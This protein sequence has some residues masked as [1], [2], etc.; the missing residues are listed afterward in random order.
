METCGC[1]KKEM[2]R[3]TNGQPVRVE[4]RNGVTT[5]Y[6][7]GVYGEFA[8]VLAREPDGPVKWNRAG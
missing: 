7:R 5:G 1:Q 3:G 4:V 8:V 6:Y 2:P